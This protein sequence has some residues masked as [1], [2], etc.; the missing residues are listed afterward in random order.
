MRRAPEGW[1][2]EV[3]T[4]GGRISW[5]LGGLL[6]AVACGSPGN[7]SPNIAGEVTTVQEGVEP[8]AN[9]ELSEGDSAANRAATRDSASEPEPLDPQPVAAPAVQAPDPAAECLR[10]CERVESQCK[11]A[12]VEACRMNC[13]DFMVAAERC[14]VEVVDALAC[15]TEASDAMICTNIVAASCVPLFSDLNACR[16]GQAEPRAPRAGG[17][18]RAQGGSGD[19]ELPAGWERT[20]DPTFSVSLPF[21][22]GARVEGDDAARRL[23]AS[24]EGVDYLVEAPARFRGEA[25]DKALLRAVLDYV[26]TPCHKALKVHGRFENQGA[27]H[28]HFDTTCSDG[29]HWRG[30]LHVAPERLVITSAQAPTT[31]RTPEVDARLESLFY[32]FRF[33]RP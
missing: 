4:R 7:Q 20:E 6:A 5:L 32:G 33:V 26:K 22:R 10:L 8:E 13:K 9:S 1:E 11:A 29:R 31:L 2:S 30:M 3:S 14:P 25:T 17:A 12:S 16:A 28:V 18:A 24:E 15:Q 23:V 19:E 27:T 21:P